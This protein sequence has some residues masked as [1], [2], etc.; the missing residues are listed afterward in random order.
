MGWDLWIAMGMV[1][2]ISG[3]AFTAGRRLSLGVYRHRPLLLMECLA[4]SIVFA[5][6]VFGRLS[7]VHAIPFS[8]AVCWSNWL[9]IFLSF[10]AGLATEMSAVRSGWRRL[11]VGV[12]LMIGVGFLML[13]VARPHLS[14]IRLAEFDQWRDGVC[15]QSNEASCGPAA[16]ATLLHQLRHARPSSGV[17]RYEMQ[18]ADLCLTSGEGTSSLGLF[19]GLKV[20]LEGTGAQARVADSDPGFW[21]AKG[22]LPNIAIVQFDSLRKR[23]HIRGFLGQDGD[24]HAVVVHSRTADGRWKVADPAMGWS[25]WD[26]AM[27]RAAFTG[28]ALFLSKER[29]PDKAHAQ[30]F[31]LAGK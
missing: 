30:P 22:Q 28:E 29:T 6:G 27:L 14:P 10:A 23:N 2:A 26:D 3:L 4:F 13:P 16:V 5:F 8:A 20:S 18:L 12:F 1:A 15:L 31:Q 9:P 24:K 17:T 21:Q 11:V 19:R 7:W 25:Y